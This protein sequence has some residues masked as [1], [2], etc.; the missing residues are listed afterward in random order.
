M[1]TD[2]RSSMYPKA[3]FAFNTV[4]KDIFVLFLRKTVKLHICDVNTFSS[5]QGH[6]LHTSENDQVIFPKFPFRE[7]SY[8]PGFTKI[9][10]EHVPDITIL[11]VTLLG[12]IPPSH[13]KEY[14]KRNNRNRPFGFRGWEMLY[15]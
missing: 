11:Q 6:N 2:V 4:N 15:L 10:P 1:S 9:E 3:D 5:Q 12:G 8:Q 7:T 13:W 14:N